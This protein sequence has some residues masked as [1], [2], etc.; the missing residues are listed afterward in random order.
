MSK[1]G[2][3]PAVEAWLG[4]RPDPAHGIETPGGVRA[5][6]AVEAALR[7]GAEAILL[8][9]PPGH[10][11]TLL[12]RSLWDAPPPGYAPLFVPFADVEPDDL[13]AWIVST[14]RRSMPSNPRAA[15]VQLLRA[16]TLG[17]KRALLLVDEVQAMP[18]ATLAEL[19]ALVAASCADARVVVAGW[20]SHT[21][22]AVP[23]VAVESLRRI[24]I[25]DSWSSSDVE[26]LLDRIASDAAVSPCALRAAVDVERLVGACEGNPRRVRKL[27]AAQLERLE[28]PDAPSAADA[29]RQPSAAR[30]GVFAR[31]LRSAR[32]ALRRLTGSSAALV[33]YAGARARQVL[34]AVRARAGG[35]ARAGRGWIAGAASSLGAAAGRRAEVA[36][37]R[38]HSAGRV[39]ASRTRSRARGVAAR[40]GVVLARFGAQ[41]RSEVVG[42]SRSLRRALDGVHP[43]RRDGRSL[44][45][46]AA[47]GFAAGAAALG[48]WIERTAPGPG[49]PGQRSETVATAI[50]ASDV[51]APPPEAPGSAADASRAPA[52]KSGRIPIHVNSH[53][54]SQVEV[55]GEPVGSTPL[56][57]S[58]EPGPH[59]FRLAMAD[60]RVREEVVEVSAERDRVAFR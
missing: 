11:K 1:I 17:G 12:L 32:D 53:P 20:D 4:D 43:P 46:W 48:M 24:R 37:V 55:D 5:R 42:A 31:E 30:E 29:A 45:P 16:R 50:Q 47:L 54:W 10:G 35:A 39:A 27:L 41:A 7:E 60:G 44:W 3:L 25:A 51:A 59:R 15:L 33:R 52:A 8:W 58:L 21:L 38:V 13:A 26:R 57:V 14:M 22:D 34:G 6:E 2:Q 36:L 19:F 40:G 18:P 9:G 28:V 23:G 49:S 56:T